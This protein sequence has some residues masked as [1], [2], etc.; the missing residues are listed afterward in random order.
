MCNDYI[1]TYPDK[2]PYK[3]LKVRFLSE[4]LTNNTMT[5]CNDPHHPEI[6][7]KHENGSFY[8]RVNGCK[9]WQ[10]MHKSHLTVA[11]IKAFYELVTREENKIL[12]NT[13]A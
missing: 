7:W 11:R 9:K 4:L 13:K 3:E 12:T 10:R 5:I 2:F 8:H 1:Y 6:E